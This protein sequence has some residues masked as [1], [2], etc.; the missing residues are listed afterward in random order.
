MYIAKLFGLNNLVV[1]TAHQAQVFAIGWKQGAAYKPTGAG[2]G[3]VNEVTIDVKAALNVPPISSRAHFV[4][5]IALP[6]ISLRRVWNQFRPCKEVG[7]CLDY[8]G[9]R[10]VLRRSLCRAESWLFVIVLGSHLVFV[11]VSFCAVFW[12]SLA[13]VVCTYLKA[14]ISFV[15]ITATLWSG[16]GHRYK[17]HHHRQCYELRYLPLNGEYLRSYLGILCVDD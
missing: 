15:V 17:W 14:A 11:T 8:N 12:F 16:D 6:A 1:Q 7:S 13:S 9:N 2:I 3:W 10:P 4:I 5:T